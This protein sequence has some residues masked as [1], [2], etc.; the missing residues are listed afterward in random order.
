MALNSYARLTV[1][2][3][4]LQG[5]TTVQ[6][7]G[8]VDVSFDHIEVYE[9]Q[10]GSASPGAASGGRTGRAELLPVLITKRVDH[11]TP[12]LYQALVSNS[13][14]EG[15]IKIF[16]TSADDGSTRH[17]FTLVLGRS[18]V[19]SI[20]SNSPDS[21]D[22]QVSARPPREVVAIIPASLTYRDEIHGV[23]FVHENVLR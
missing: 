10:W 19:Q 9:L 18:R 5:D 20:S 13:Q 22:P 21:L 15:D 2:G 23:E 1:N 6:S 17:R 14:V 11:A 8:G 16:D 7:I 12:R 4:A 3:E